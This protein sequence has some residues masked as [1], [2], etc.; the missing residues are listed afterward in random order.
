MPF[1]KIKRGKGRGKYRSPSGRV[2]NKAQVKRY[3]ARGGTFDFDAFFDAVY[4]LTKKPTHGARIGDSSNHFHCDAVQRRD[5]TGTTD[6]R[7][8]YRA[9]F[10][11]R[12]RRVLRLAR[13]VLVEQD[14]LG[15]RSENVASLA[16][17]ASLSGQ[18]QHGQGSLASLG[19]D[20]KIKAFQAW[21]D[22][23][24]Q[25]EVLGGDGAWLGEMVRRPWQ[26]ALKRAM[27]LSKQQVS[28]PDSQAKQDALTAL[29]V[30]ETQGVMEAASQRAVRAVA[31]G[32]LAG[33]DGPH[34][35][36][37]IADAITAIGIA[38]SRPVVEVIISKAFT[39]ATVDQF[40]EARV[41][42]VGVIPETIPA[43]RSPRTTDAEGPGSRGGTSTRTV[44][45]IKRVSKKLRRLGEFVGIQ[46]AG[47][48]LVCPICE[49]L[50]AA[51]PY[52]LDTAQSLIPA[53]PNCRCAFV[54]AESPVVEEDAA[55]R[56]EFDPNQPRDPDG[57]WGGGGGGEGGTG[58]E[59]D[60]ERDAGMSKRVKA[61]DDVDGLR[62][63][64]DV[65]NMGSIDS[66]LTD[67]EILSGIREVD[68]SSFQGAGI[69][70]KRLSYSKTEH[71][72]ILRLAEAIRES[73]EIN[74]LIVVV[75][76]NNLKEGPYILEGG[77]R[78]TALQVLGK[79][80]FP[81]KVI[82]SYD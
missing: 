80:S 7:R 36:R 20:S 21:F 16:L 51:G 56:D 75:E 69:N 60:P 70:P 72:R 43:V 64:E 54:P 78:F 12:W 17:R 33:E 58:G 68:V 63:R 8:R 37:R 35:V 2:F 14:I 46:T 81:A 4:D 42:H 57:K 13:T 65:P 40:R 27:R 44:S 23:T 10:E 61:G 77:H 3:H 15:L 55:L 38:R 59:R 34:V 53:H 41:T 18:V 29:A 48:D 30:S 76:A 62:V 73:G 47:D 82:V 71:D 31:E 22:A 25:R 66:S 49:D 32:L 1:K 11:R 52:S 6:L 74:P 9:E 39:Q 19:S 28:P 5:P 26:R 67:Y 79:K 50:E 24:L 45:R